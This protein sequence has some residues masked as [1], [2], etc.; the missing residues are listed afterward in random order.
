MKTRCVGEC[1][2]LESGSQMCEKHGMKLSDATVL[3]TAQRKNCP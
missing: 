1:R 3:A 2:D